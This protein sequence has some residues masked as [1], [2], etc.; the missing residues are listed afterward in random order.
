MYTC[1]RIPTYVH[2][3]ETQCAREERIQNNDWLSRECDDLPYPTGS[4]RLKYTVLIRTKKNQNQ[5]L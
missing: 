5:I 2:V 1:I 3:F 4:I